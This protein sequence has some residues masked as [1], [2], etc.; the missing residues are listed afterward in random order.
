MAKLERARWWTLRRAQ[1]R[2]PATYRCPFCGYQL[3][4]MS[5]HVLIAPEGDLDRRRHAHAECA[6]A[7]REAGRLPSYDEWRRTQPRRPGLLHRL[8]RR[9]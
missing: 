1:S 2:K 5:A 4:A 6:A 8:F 7:A 9:S 3:H